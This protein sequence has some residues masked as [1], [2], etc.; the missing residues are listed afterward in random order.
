MATNGF[1]IAFGRIVQYQSFVILFMIL[2]LFMFS[3]SVK[4]EKWRVKGIYFGFIFWAISIPSHYDGVFIAPFAAYFLFNWVKSYVLPVETR[5]TYLKHLFLALIISGVMLASFYIPFLLHIS[6]ATKS[7]WQGRLEGTGGKISSSKVLF[8]AYQ[9]IYVIHIYTLLVLFGGLVTFKELIKPTISSTIK[10]DR[11]KLLA[12][13]AWFAIPFVFFEVL[14]DIPGTHIYAYL[15]PVFVIMG[16]AIVAA[17]D[18]VSYVALKL[19]AIV[20]KASIVLTRLGIFV[21]FAFIF[22]QS[23]AIFVNHTYEYPWEPEPFM[24]WEFHQP[25]PIFHLS[26]F[27]FPYYRHWNSIS[28]YVTTTENNGYYSTNERSSISRYHVPFKKDTD[29][30]GH[31]I[32]IINPQ[33]FTPNPIQD[34]AKYWAENNEPDKTF[35]SY[36]PKDPENERPIVNIYYM[37]QGSLDELMLVEDTTADE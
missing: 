22:L 27:G 7:Y 17:E 8:Q 23:H 5:F 31:L 10:S 11:L 4:K 33:S 32:H 35:Y 19:S 13:L 34:K 1:L 30:S 26:M 12:L 21:V 37:P 3:L 6:D 9:P 25:S 2:A 15:I 29:S 28:T 16:L 36:N 24:I 18:I 14:V 20:Q